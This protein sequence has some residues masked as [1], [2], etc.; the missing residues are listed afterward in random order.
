MVGFGDVVD[1]PSGKKCR[2]GK[3]GEDHEFA[4][5]LR[6]LLEKCNESLNGIGSGVVPLNGTHLSSTNRD[7]S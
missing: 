7:D 4:T 3:L 2:Q 6:A 5:A 1:E